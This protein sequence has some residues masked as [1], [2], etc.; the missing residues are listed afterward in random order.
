MD[1]LKQCEIKWLC[2]SQGHYMYI[3][4]LVLKPL[5]C[6]YAVLTMHHYPKVDPYVTCFKWI[7]WPIQHFWL[8]KRE[9]NLSKWKHL[10]D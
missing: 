8:R 4:Q 10:P 7:K 3:T 2:I 6:E 9:K 1:G 5:N